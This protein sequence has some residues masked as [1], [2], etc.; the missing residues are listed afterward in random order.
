MAVQYDNQTYEDMSNKS[1]FKFVFP[2]I[3]KEYEALA[4]PSHIEPV[5]TIAMSEHNTDLCLV[6]FADTLYFISVYDDKEK[7]FKFFY[8]DRH[9]NHTLTL[10]IAHRDTIDDYESDEMNDFMERHQSSDYHLINETFDTGEE[11]AAFLRG[12]DVFCDGIN[13]DY[14]HI[15]EEAYEILENRDDE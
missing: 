7:K 15:T 8:E 1:T 10:M 3:S 4:N 5:S 13:Q 14:T 2:K 6:Y 11:G 9:E 12:L